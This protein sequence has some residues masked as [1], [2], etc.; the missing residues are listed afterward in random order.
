MNLSNYS[1]V[2]KEHPVQFNH[3]KNIQQVI[4]LLKHK[5]TDNIAT[6]GNNKLTDPAFYQELEALC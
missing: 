4:Y 3:S 5:M 6:T 1:V 2:L